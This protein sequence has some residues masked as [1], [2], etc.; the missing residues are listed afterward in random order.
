MKFT[1]VLFSTLLF[2]SCNNQSSENVQADKKKSE[3]PNEVKIG[4]RII[5]KN[6]LLGTYMGDL[7][8]ADCKG[9]KT[10]LTLGGNNRANYTERKLTIG[11]NES[12]IVDGTWSI[13][14]DSS[15][16]T[17]LGRDTKNEKL[18]F[19]KDGKN[20]LPMNSETELKDCGAANCALTKTETKSI[21]A[22][23]AIKKAKEQAE[24]KKKI[25]GSF[26]KVES[27]KK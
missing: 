19:K 10:V 3:Q 7:P 11:K 5:T 8:C 14:A 12:R 13:N 20:L 18:Y 22:S 16:I 9:I 17:V 4:N 25:N 15:L 24:E 26:Q 27:S 2:F 6:D 23:E 1:L 21:N